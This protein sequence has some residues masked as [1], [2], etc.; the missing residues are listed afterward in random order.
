MNFTA[1]INYDGTRTPLKT[2]LFVVLCAAWL[3]PGLVGHDPWKVDEAVVFGMVTEMLH[4]KDWV[5]F[6]I[7]G[8]PSLEKAPL[9]VW[10]AAALAK[11]L[12]RVIPLH[13]AAR[14]ASGL[15]VGLALGFLSLAA[16]ALMGERAVRM[17]VL[18]ML[19]CLGLLIRAH[20]M[21]TDVAGLAGLAVALYGLAV[22]LKRPVRGGAI[23]GVGMGLAFL[24]DGPLPFG[25][26]I[27]ALAILPLASPLWRTRAY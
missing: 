5:I 9:F 14:L 3:L 20:E 12:G 8:E 7:A 15:Y 10:T 21:T 27:A 19:G 13:D 2:V 1:P 22:S 11:L 18:L 16:N 17:A 25:M 23:T 4:S 24:G 6:A 26:M